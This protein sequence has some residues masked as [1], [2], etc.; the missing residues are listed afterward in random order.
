MSTIA[1]ILLSSFIGGMVC[2]VLGFFMFFLMTALG[3]TK[4]SE[5]FGYSLIVSL[6]CAFIGAMIGLVIGIGN[7]GVLGG[8]IVGVLATLCVAGFYVF[9]F[10]T[11]GKT[12]YFF[13]ESRIIFIVLTLPT[14]LTGIGTAII[15]NLIYKP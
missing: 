2:A 6:G 12:A 11:P 1:K 9:F 14:I 10:S 3:G 5:A 7:L 13:G 15:K 8:S 4:A